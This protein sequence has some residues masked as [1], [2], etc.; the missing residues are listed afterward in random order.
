M[1]NKKIDFLSHEEHERKQK[2]F[3]YYLAFQQKK[4][5]SIIIEFV[6]STPYALKEKWIVE[7]I[8]ELMTRGQH[9][10]L[11]KIFSPKKGQ[12][13]LKNE[14]AIRNLIIA[15]KVDRFVRQGMNKTQ[16]FEYIY[17]KDNL[18]VSKWN[19]DVGQIRKIYYATK[20]KQPQLYVSNLENVLEIN[21]YPAKVEVISY[22]KTHSFFGLLKMRMKT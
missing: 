6:R 1:I 5:L 7:Y 13:W 10:S 8:T 22:G 2:S 9:R 20:R 17:S 21:V 3:D 12:R 11:R 15:D 14:V 4:D 19:I 18:I 16:A